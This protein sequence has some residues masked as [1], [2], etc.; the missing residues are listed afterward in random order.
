MRNI[1]WIVLLLVLSNMCSMYGCVP[2]KMAT[3]ANYHNAE[4]V[5]ME[6]LEREIRAV[7][8]IVKQNHRH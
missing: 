8:T 6:N 4:N 5:R 7:M 2:V 3:F 1:L